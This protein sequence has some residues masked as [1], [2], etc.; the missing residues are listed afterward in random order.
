MTSTKKLYAILLLVALVLLL[1]SVSR[2]DMRAAQPSGNTSTNPT[3]E[4]VDRIVANIWEM[5][6]EGNHVALINGDEV[7]L[8][9]IKNP[10]NPRIVSYIQLTGINPQYREFGSLQT[11]ILDG[12]YVYITWVCDDYECEGASNMLEVVDISDR[13][14]P[15]TVAVLE[16]ETPIYKMAVWDSML[17]VNGENKL[18]LIDISNPSMPILYNTIPLDVYIYRQARIY[19]QSQADN[20]VYLYAP[21]FGLQIIDITNPA[22]I[23]VV[24]RIDVCVSDDLSFTEISNRWYVYMDERCDNDILAFDVTDP[25]NPIQVNTYDLGNDENTLSVQMTISGQH[26]FA[27]H[28][29]KHHDD[30]GPITKTMHILDISDPT[31]PELLDTTDVSYI[32]GVADIVSTDSLVLIADWYTGVHILDVTNP[33][34]PTNIAM[35]TVVDGRAMAINNETLYIG[36]NNGIR[37]YDVFNPLQLEEMAYFEMEEVIIGILYNNGYLLTVENGGAFRIIDVTSPTT[38]FQVSYTDWGLASTDMIVQGQ[39]G[40]PGAYVFVSNYCPFMIPC[41]PG[42]IAIDVSDPAA[43]AI[44]NI[45][46]D[47][48]E[49]RVVNIELKDDYLLA[50]TES[51]HLMAW[52]VTNPAM[53][54]LLND[55]ALNESWGSGLVMAENYAYVATDEISPTLQVWDLTSPSTPQQLHR[56]ETDSTHYGL[57]IDQ[58]YLYALTDRAQLMVYDL[59]NPTIPTLVETAEIP[60]PWKRLYNPLIIES[61][62][63]YVLSEGLSVWHDTE[64]VLGH[65]LDAWQRPYSGVTITADAN[66]IAGSGLTGSYKPH[67]GMEGTYEL[68]AVLGQHSTW[69]ASRMVNFDALTEK[70]DFYMLGLPVSAEVTPG[71]ETTLRYVDTLGLTTEVIFPVGGVQETV[72]M[73]LRPTMAFNDGSQRFVGNAF[74]IEPIEEDVRDYAD[75]V[76][77]NPLE[78]RLNYS[79]LGIHSVNETTLRLM[80]HTEAGW[81]DVME[82]CPNRHGYTHDLEQNILQVSICHGGEFALFGDTNLIFL[83]AIWR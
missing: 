45:L 9:D 76:F 1:G 18:T 24:S 42:L 69:P 29:E 15:K 44:A 39:V 82:A 62:S 20:K 81:M 41:P 72:T 48:Y 49:R 7:A 46:V 52:D 77:R 30:F 70:Q 3:L 32:Y 50:L 38:P 36:A 26:A 11:A 75:Y 4:M 53:P 83:P 10:T 61:G 59:S 5:D 51:G 14:A 73:Q 19:I 60:V 55:T 17:Y 31:I 64:D 57:T 34:T 33:T 2:Y 68:Q 74:V 80:I 28:T 54:L 47:G 58:N 79:E 21:G 37:I 25:T 22:S 63:A 78:V 66:P 6:V 8:M 13:T 27:I 67:D 43:P 23:E 71:T 35:Q 56:L 12:A 65:V 16:V 40:E